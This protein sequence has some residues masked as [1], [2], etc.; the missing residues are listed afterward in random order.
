MKEYEERLYLYLLYSI[1]VVVIGSFIFLV[2]A[3]MLP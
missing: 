1:A 2:W 3:G